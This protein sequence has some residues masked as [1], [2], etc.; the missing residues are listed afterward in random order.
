MNIRELRR[1]ISAAP[2][3]TKFIIIKESIL[4]YEIKPG[5]EKPKKV[6]TENN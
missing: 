1:L 4:N 2:T 3:G 5:M 6:K